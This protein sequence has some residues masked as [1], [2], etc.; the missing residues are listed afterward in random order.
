[1][2][3]LRNIYQSL[4]RDHS[5]VWYLQRS[6]IEND[7]L[8]IP[9]VGADTSKL[10][11]RKEKLH[12]Q[13]YPN[14]IVCEIHEDKHNPHD[15]PV[16]TVNHLWDWNKIGTIGIGVITLYALDHVFNDGKLTRKVRK[17]LGI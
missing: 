13:C 7:P 12:A 15:F 9:S 2:D 16:G 8:W 4:R 10:H 5:L 6:D 14:D 11:W 17:E 1:M 3:D